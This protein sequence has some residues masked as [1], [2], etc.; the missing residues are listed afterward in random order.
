M[1]NGGPQDRYNLDVATWRGEMQ[2]DM[3]NLK[4]SMDEFRDSQAVMAAD[5]RE[6]REDWAKAKGAGRLAGAVAGILGA[7]TVHLLTG[8]F[9]K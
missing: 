4:R 7:G 3:R 1:A 8:W 2:S 6:I 9:K 5:V